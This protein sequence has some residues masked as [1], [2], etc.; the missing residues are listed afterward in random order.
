MKHIRSSLTSNRTDF[1]KMAG[2]GV[3]VAIL[4][5]AGALRAKELVHPRGSSIAT[6]QVLFVGDYLASINGKFW[7]IMQDDGNFVVYEGSSTNTRRYLW[8]SIQAASP[9]KNGY[10]SDRSQRYFAVMQ[11][12]GNFVVYQGTPNR[13]R[14]L[15]GSA[16]A[17]SY[18]T[19]GGDYAAELSDDGNFC[20]Y[21]L[22]P[23][24]APSSLLFS[25]NTA[26][27]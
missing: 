24:G 10:R 20:V 27:R 15:W 3:G 22:G 18:Q 23:P 25:T 11:N 16:Q 12:D 2:V 14:Y 6:N 4:N 8:G 13:K 1:I 19:M 5:P 9:W 26:G 7:A 21:K 17:A